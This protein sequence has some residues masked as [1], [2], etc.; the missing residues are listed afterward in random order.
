MLGLIDLHERVASAAPDCKH[1]TYLIIFF[2]QDVRQDVSAVKYTLSVQGQSDLQNYPLIMADDKQMR[3]FN[4]RL[5]A[6]EK[7]VKAIKDAVNNISLEEKL[8]RAIENIEEKLDKLTSFI[9]LQGEPQYHENYKVSFVEQA[10]Y[11]YM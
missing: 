5:S 6:V 7:D 3:Q 11:S 8:G 9:Q 10:I 2:P 1:Y 4:V